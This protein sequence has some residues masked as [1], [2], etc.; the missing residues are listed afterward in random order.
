MVR[1]PVYNAAILSNFLLILG[2]L[3][4]DLIK[5]QVIEEKLISE[6]TEILKPPLT[7]R[8]RRGCYKEQGCTAL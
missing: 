8:T 6:S 4:S 7:R 5:M 2:F 3:Y 1:G